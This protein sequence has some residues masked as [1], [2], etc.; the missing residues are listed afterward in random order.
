MYYFDLD[1][2]EFEMQVNNFDIVD[3]VL[4]FMK[5]LEYVMN[6]IG[7]DIDIE[8]WLVWVK[9]GEDEKIFKKCLVIGQ[10][11]SWYENLI[12]WKKLEEV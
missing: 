6:L 5:M 3:E 2:N 12:Y 11:F 4:E 7:V 9:S 10:R 8:E 1:G